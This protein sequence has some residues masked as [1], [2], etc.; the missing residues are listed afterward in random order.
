MMDIDILLKSFKDTSWTTIFVGVFSTWILYIV[1][2]AFYRFYLSP[3]A[4]FP[5]PKL[6]AVSRWY[7]FYYEVVLRGQYSFHIQDL[8]KK[9]GKMI[10]DQSSSNCFNSLRSNYTCVSR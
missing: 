6:A 9:Y 10:G 1:G 8:H 7:E 3:I 4:N 2:R 5:G